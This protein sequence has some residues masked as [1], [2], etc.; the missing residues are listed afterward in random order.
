GWIKGNNGKWHYTLFIQNGRIKDD[1][2]VRLMTGLRQIAQE[3]T[4]EF[5]ITPNQNLIIS[6]VTSQ[7][8]KK[9]E[10]LMQQYGLNDGA[11]YTALRRNSMACVALPTCG[12]AMAESERYFPT[13]LDKL[14]LILDEA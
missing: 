6:N 5:R 7:K 8:K 4:G 13:L 10:A 9:I 3:H 14:E 1:G 2:D 11:H 12:L